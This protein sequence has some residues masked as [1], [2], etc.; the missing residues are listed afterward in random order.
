M[1][2]VGVSKSFLK[3][4]TL[5][6]KHE[7]CT[8]PQ[9]EPHGFSAPTHSGTTLH[10]SGTQPLRTFSGGNRSSALCRHRL[11]SPVSVLRISGIIQYA[12]FCFWSLPFTKVLPRV[13]VGCPF[14]CMTALL[15][16]HLGS[17]C[18]GAMSSHMHIRPFLLDSPPGGHLLGRGVSTHSALADLPA[19]LATCWYHLTVPPVAAGVTPTSS[20]APHV[21]S[22][23]LASLLEADTSV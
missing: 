20:A 21:L 11:L 4:V 10:T 15:N 17:S 14:R 7:R 9:W 22:F 12:L 8:D 2:T 16:G 1:G 6:I 3:R 18:L 23:I 13:F 5:G 19:N